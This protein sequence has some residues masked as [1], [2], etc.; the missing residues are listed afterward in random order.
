VKEFEKMC[1]KSVETAKQKANVIST[2]MRE[3]GVTLEH[4]NALHLVGRMEGFAN[5]HA[6]RK[7]LT[8]GT[9][10]VRVPGSGRTAIGVE[11]TADLFEQ[12]KARGPEDLVATDVSSGEARFLVLERLTD[13][14]GN[15]GRPARTAEEADYR[16]VLLLQKE[17]YLSSIVRLNGV[18]GVLFEM[19][20]WCAESA[21]DVAETNPDVRS[22]AL[23]V[24]AL[25]R[26]HKPLCGKFNYTD[27]LIPERSA[28]R[29]GNAA[30][31]VFVAQGCLTL[32]ERKELDNWLQRVGHPDF[33]W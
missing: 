27:V 14:E 15:W 8:S 18:T 32:D 10:I 31:W 33:R 4:S 30:L 24:T 25:A 26:W 28:V 22:Y 29:S 16:E 23:T 5:W 13:Q 3:R 9:P 19:E 17:G 12:P 1:I 7:V 6:L 11:P 21:P 20:Y 2:I